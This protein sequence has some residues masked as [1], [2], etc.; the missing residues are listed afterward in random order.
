MTIIKYY[1]LLFLFV[2]SCTNRNGLKP[3]YRTEV[4]CLKCAVVSKASCNYSENCRVEV[5]SK[6][7][8]FGDDA[9][10]QEIYD[11]K[12]DIFRWHVTT[13]VS[14]V[15]PGDVICIYNY[16]FYRNNIL[17]SSSKRVR[18]KDLALCGNK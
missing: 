4:E 17:D 16:H 14:P 18:F 12:L 9:L 13:E 6:Y 5:T 3:S 2:V 15:I 1:I 10:T 7:Y 11:N 8:T